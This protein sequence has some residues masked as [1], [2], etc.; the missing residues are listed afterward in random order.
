MKIKKIQIMSKIK[1]NL[2][3]LLIILTFFSSIFLILI[4]LSP[5]NENGKI[6]SLNN[7]LTSNFFYHQSSITTNFSKF[8]YRYSE[9]IT[10]FVLYT[11]LYLDAQI[12]N[13][14][15]DCSI[16]NNY[17]APCG[18]IGN[19]IYKI[20]LNSTSAKY[21]F[22]KI[23]MN[24]VRISASSLLTE[25]KTLKLE[26][27]MELTSTNLKIIN[28]TP[29]NVKEDNL[30]NVSFSYNN[31]FFPNQRI[32][33]ASIS[34]SINNSIYLTEIEQSELLLNNSVYHL[35]NL[36]NG[37][38]NLEFNFT[39]GFNSVLNL[40]ATFNKTGF[41]TNSVHV[42]INT[43]V[44]ATNVTYSTSTFQVNWGD[45]FTF[46]VTYWDEDNNSKIKDAN[47]SVIFDNND[48]NAIILQKESGVY[49]LTINTTNKIAGNRT[50]KL[51]CSKNGFESN[52]SWLILR[53]IANDSEISTSNT[54]ISYEIY[55]NSTIQ[56]Y[57]VN[58]TDVPSGNPI[59]NASAQFFLTDY[60]FNDLSIKAHYFVVFNDS[61]GN[62]WF[63]FNSSGLHEGNYYLF[64]TLEQHNSTFAW[65]RNFTMFNISI[66]ALNSFLN[67]STD[68]YSP[69]EQ[70]NWYQYEI[71]TIYANFSAIFLDSYINVSWGKVR[72]EVRNT[73]L[74]LI[75][76]GNLNYYEGCFYSAEFNLSMDITSGTLFYLIL[77]SSALDIKNSSILINLNVSAKRNATISITAMNWHVDQTPKL[78]VEGEFMSFQFSVID[79]ESGLLINNET[80]ICKMIIVDTSGFQFEYICEIEIENGW[81]AFACQIPLNLYSLQFS[82]ECK[83][84]LKMWDSGLIQLSVQFYPI[85]I[86][87]LVFLGYT[88]YI[89]LIIGVLLYIG[90]RYRF[91]YK[92]MKEFKEG[93]RDTISYRF[94]S[95]SNLIHIMVY[96]QSTSEFLYSYSIPSVELSTYTMNSVLESISMYDNMKVS[97][98]EIYLRDEARLIMHDGEYT[99]IVMIT[100]ELPS[101]EM[102][103]QMEQFLEKFEL[104]FGKSIPDWRKD[105]SR[106]ARMIDM[107]FA[108]ELIEECFEI[109]LTFQHTTRTIPPESEKLTLLEEKILDIAKQTEKKSGPF[110]LQRLVGRAQM[111][112]GER[113]KL[114]LILEAAYNLRKKG[115]LKWLS[116]QEAER[117]REQI[118]RE[119]ER[120]AASDERD[121][122]KTQKNDKKKTFNN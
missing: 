24:D 15:V 106:L 35:Y 54:S 110:L 67:V 94:K 92:P 119:T 78:L 88:W 101:V 114:L 38:Y 74:A 19:G 73:S 4:N 103:K 118:Y 65:E 75:Y 66:L 59:R 81:A 120:K 37:I 86:Y 48:L 12:N 26:I 61:N 52:Y 53:I 105:L 82:F 85:T 56:N 64:F 97:N 3:L 113:F 45:N 108:N 17:V 5:N 80:L 6:N 77:N 96:D 91:K 42:Q 23:G 11:D 121:F 112:I 87:P 41:M 99:R 55:V 104:K 89:Y 39:Y 79:K 7:D 34:A 122:K 25:V 63:N 57:R 95:A 49:N 44:N 47:I 76:S 20:I 84:S 100:K 72:Y 22:F 31:S 50:L 8:T 117:L 32:L 70:I 51:Y 43:L 2:I 98:Q 1:K 28:A 109:S 9:N 111:E 83:R 46:N 62:Y 40:S 90:Y 36:S 115:Y 102:R 18:F 29:I 21:D 69:T 14:E 13:A 27:K 116:E 16:N 68:L 10:I 30:F 33:S 58:F 60:D 93:F 71:I 107:K